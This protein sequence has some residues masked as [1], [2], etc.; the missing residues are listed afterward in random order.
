M[1]QD[2][3]ARTGERT[4]AQCSLL[5]PSEKEP[6]RPLEWAGWI[7]KKK[8]LQSG[9]CIQRFRANN[10]VRG[11]SILTSRLRFDRYEHSLRSACGDFLTAHFYPISQRRQRQRAMEGSILLL[12]L[13]VVPGACTRF[14]I[15]HGLCLCSLARVRQ[16][17]SVRTTEFV[18]LYSPLYRVMYVGGTY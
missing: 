8:V 17:V 16:S 15:P 13:P 4:Q 10:A 1:R 3:V 12:L 11:G 2:S 6:M 9:G 14:D 5:I 18:S 7:Q